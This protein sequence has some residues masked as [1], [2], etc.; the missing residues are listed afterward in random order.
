MNLSIPGKLGGENQL[1]FPLISFSFTQT[2][3]V[4]DDIGYL[5]F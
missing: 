3:I 2:R 1:Y 4:C 5:K